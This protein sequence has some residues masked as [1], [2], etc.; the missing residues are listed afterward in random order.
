MG[1]AR[2]SRRSPSMDAYCLDRYS[3]KHVHRMPL[4]RAQ[5]AIDCAEVAPVAS[6]TIPA[7]FQPA[8]RRPGQRRGAAAPA[9]RGHLPGS[10]SGRSACGH[11]RQCASDRLRNV[12]DVDRQLN[13]RHPVIISG[14]RVV[15]LFAR[16][17]G[18]CWMDG[19][20]RRGSGAGG[21]V[22]TGGIGGG[23]GKAPYSQLGRGSLSFRNRTEL[24]AE[25]TGAA[26]AP[27]M[28][29]RLLRTA[30]L[31]RVLPSIQPDNPSARRQTSQLQHSRAF[32]Q[33]P[34][35]ANAGPAALAS[36][37]CEHSAGRID[38]F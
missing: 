3:W 5:R 35:P 38:L 1:V 18:S 21:Q 24:L 27:V 25:P 10:H 34:G 13:A 19:R 17:A 23:A 9:V 31:P 8:L 4:L 22:G 36:V 28:G 6:T 33:A 7:T 29:P 37:G 30:A 26:I 16:S 2:G 12:A 32:G 15:C 11:R 14:V 20:C